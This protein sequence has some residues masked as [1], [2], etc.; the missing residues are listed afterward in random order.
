M[1]TVIYD[2]VGMRMWLRNSLEVTSVVTPSFCKYKE[3]I[4]AYR[5]GL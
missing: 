2:V 4:K 1:C 3:K 5:C